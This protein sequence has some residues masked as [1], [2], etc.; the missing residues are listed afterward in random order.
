MR[1]RTGLQTF[2][3]LAHKMCVLFGVWRGPI[4]AAIDANTNATTE[5]KNQLKALISAVDTACTAIDATR[6]IWE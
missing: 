6:V 2:L 5:Q 1:I 3:K 4:I